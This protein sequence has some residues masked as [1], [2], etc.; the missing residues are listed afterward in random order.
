M[1]PRRS[2][3]KPRISATR[4]RRAASPPRYRAPVAS[5][6]APETPTVSIISAAPSTD[7]GRGSLRRYFGP[8]AD[9]TVVASSPSRSATQ[10]VKDLTAD[11]ARARDR[12]STSAPALMR[13]PGAQVG[14]PG[15]HHR[16]QPL[17]PA[18]MLRQKCQIPRDIARYR[19]SS[20]WHLRPSAHAV[21]ASQSPAPAAGRPRSP[22]PSFHCPA[23]DNQRRIVRSNTPA[24][25]ARRSVPCVGLN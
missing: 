16:A 1:T 4:S 8:R 17:G 3:P 13:H 19:R 21:C 6:R 20:Y 9:S 2:A 15:L 24:K 5:R 11:S 10:A 25:K 22:A 14:L 18:A 23:H 7:R 12:A